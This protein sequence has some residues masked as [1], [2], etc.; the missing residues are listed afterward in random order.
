[1]RTEGMVVTMRISGGL[2]KR[3]IFLNGFDVCIGYEGGL[4]QSALTLTVFL[5]KNV[6]GSLL[7]AQHLP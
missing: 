3:K 2:E 1:M 7:P 4:T 5:L 6:S